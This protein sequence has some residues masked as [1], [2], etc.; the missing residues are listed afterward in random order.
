MKRQKESK[1]ET[2]RNW[3]T[4]KGYLLPIIFA[5]LMLFAISMKAQ[6][7]EQVR[8]EIIKQDILFPEIVTAQAILETGW[9]KCEQ[10]SFRFN[11]IFGFR[12]SYKSTEDNPSGYLIFNHWKES[13]AY[14]KTWQDKHFTS[15]SYFEFLVERGYAENMNSYIEKL[16]WIIE[17]K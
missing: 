17:N 7:V 8:R 4:D 6:T 13:V 1:L 12:L 14:Y 5:L 9:F 2:F 16:N 3:L 11:N 15:G 10:C